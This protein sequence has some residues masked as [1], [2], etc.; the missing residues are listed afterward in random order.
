MPLLWSFAE[1]T[2]HRVR[3]GSSRHFRPLLPVRRRY[4]SI[5]AA[6]CMLVLGF[7]SLDKEMSQR[8]NLHTLN[9]IT[10]SWTSS[11]LAHPPWAHPPWAHLPCVLDE[12]STP[13]LGCFASFRLLFFTSAI[14][15]SRQRYGSLTR[16]NKEPQPFEKAYRIFCVKEKDLFTSLGVVGRGAVL[17]FHLKVIPVSI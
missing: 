17:L 12:A 5:S 9:D 14:M 8:Y 1:P 11:S 10:L 3:K 15:I 7:Y 6:W 13:L 4:G 16:R 2:S